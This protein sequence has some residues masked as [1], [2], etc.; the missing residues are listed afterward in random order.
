M[1]TLENVMQTHGKE[2]PSSDAQNKNLGTGMS[3][4]GGSGVI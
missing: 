3:H 2:M 1:S 4:Q